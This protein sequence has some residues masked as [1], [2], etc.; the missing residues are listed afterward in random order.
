MEELK[1]DDKEEN[2][3]NVKENIKEEINKPEMKLP[4]FEAALK[5]DFVE[6]KPERYRERMIDA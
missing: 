4:E 1:E 2:K 5:A 3:L 6:E